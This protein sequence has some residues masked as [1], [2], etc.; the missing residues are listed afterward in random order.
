MSSGAPVRD[1]SMS[2]RWVS[3]RTSRRK[4]RKR[5]PIPGASSWSHSTGVSDSVIAASSR[6]STSSSGRY[7]VAI[8]SNSHSSPKGQ[9]PNPST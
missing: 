4:A 5:S 1:P 2:R 6:S 7:E 9:V 3:A 8:A